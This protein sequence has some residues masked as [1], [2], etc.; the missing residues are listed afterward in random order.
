MLYGCTD[1]ADNIMD[2]CDGCAVHFSGHRRERRRMA[3]SNVSQGLYRIGEEDGDIDIV[4]VHGFRGD[5]QQTWIRGPSGTPETPEFNWPVKLQQDLKE[6]VCPVRIWLMKYSAPAL[7]A[8]QP[9]DIELGLK[10]RAAS[11]CHGALEGDDRLGKRPIVFIAHSLGGL[12]VKA[13]LDREWVNDN[14]SDILRQTKAVVFLGTPHSGAGLANMVGTLLSSVSSWVRKAGAT[15]GEILGASFGGPPIIG[16]VIGD[17]VGKKLGHQSDPSQ[18]LESLR[19]NNPELADLMQ[20]YRTLAKRLSIETLSCF[21]TKNYLGQAIVVPQSSADPGVG[22]F[23]AVEDADHSEICKPRDESAYVYRMVRRVIER[24]AINA[25]R[26]SKRPVFGEE[27]ERIFR[28]LRGSRFPM[29][30]RF[31]WES[32]SAGPVIGELLGEIKDIPREKPT[33]PASNDRWSVEAW[34]NFRRRI[35]VE[36]FHQCEQ[37]IRNGDMKVDEPEEKAAESSQF[38]I[39]KLVLIAWRKYRSEQALED[40]RSLIEQECGF[41]RSVHKPTL[42]VLFQAIHNLDKVLSDQLTLSLGTELRPV[43]ESITRR[44]EKEELDSDNITRGRIED[45]IKK[46]QSM[47]QASLQLDRI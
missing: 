39:D 36:F 27:A 45:L 29:L 33:L 22:Q 4:F 40:M 38:D 6:S 10:Q 3:Q 17:L 30:S 20:S 9:F 46:I 44:A 24:A 14:K 12:I 32:D 16:G 25:H 7:A 31:K 28:N 43:R 34:I 47:A 13:I 37:A 41:V 15:I 21:E 18:T 23:F 42:T 11:I 1:V 19:Q 35:A 2:G 8:S 5:A 26:G